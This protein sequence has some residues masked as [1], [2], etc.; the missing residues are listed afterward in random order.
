[1]A[2]QSC[3]G[4]SR[5]SMMHTPQTPSN[6]HLQ[7]LV[8]QALAVHAAHANKGVHVRSS[9]MHP[10]RPSLGLVLC[11]G[12]LDWELSCPGKLE[13]SLA[14]CI[15]LDIERVATLPEVGFPEVGCA[16]YL[17]VDSP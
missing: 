4:E 5:R 2:L 7:S 14:P 16:L 1:M 10:V 12:H 3:G 15:A 6:I 13:Q 11:R 17:S 9:S 8:V